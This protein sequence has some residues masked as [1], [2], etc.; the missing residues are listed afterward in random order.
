[1][2]LEVGTRTSK[3]CARIRYMLMGSSLWLIILGT[4]FFCFDIF[5]ADY[6]DLLL[7]SYSESNLFFD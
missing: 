1:M 7:T 2:T 3:E 4:S 5:G 6:V